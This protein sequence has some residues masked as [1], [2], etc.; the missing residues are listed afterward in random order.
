[1]IEILKSA[2][3]AVTRYIIPTYCCIKRSFIHYISVICLNINRYCY[4]LQRCVKR[5]L[6]GAIYK[7]VLYSFSPDMK[8][9]KICFQT[10]KMNSQRFEIIASI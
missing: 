4:C 10:C 1:M 5:R 8:S 3:E 2:T 7:I 9:E 6:L